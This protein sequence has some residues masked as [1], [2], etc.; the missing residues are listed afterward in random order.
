ML[1]AS[2]VTL[3]NFPMAFRLYFFCHFIIC[4]SSW[5]R[6]DN[7]ENG[8][9]FFFGL[10]TNM[11]PCTLFISFRFVFIFPRVIISVIF[12]Q[13]FSWWQ[14]TIM[15]WKKAVCLLY[16]IIKFVV[17]VYL[18]LKTTFWPK[19]GKFKEREKNEKTKQEH[20][21]I[22]IIKYYINLKAKITE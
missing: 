13:P 2:V 7:V 9:F 14:C 21:H 16:V 3:T 19:N 12:Y 11:P 17:Q 5:F 8:S 1:F 22:Y 18:K 6:L 10:V 20:P 15:C 4:I